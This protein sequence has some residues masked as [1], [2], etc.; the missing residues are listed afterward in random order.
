MLGMDS[1][2]EAP[3]SPRAIGV[4]VARATGARVSDAPRVHLDDPGWDFAPRTQ[5]PD[6]NYGQIPIPDGPEVFGAP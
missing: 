6:R 2:D 4:E 5:M 3:L 1:R